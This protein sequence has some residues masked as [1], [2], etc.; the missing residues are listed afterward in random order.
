MDTTN[1]IIGFLKDFGPTVWRYVKYQIYHNNYVSE[2]Q[3]MQELLKDR[4]DVVDANLR[5]Q[6]MQ[7]GKI[8]NKEVRA[9]LDEAQRETAEE[10]IEDPI[11]KGGCF[12]YI[13]SSRKLDKKT[14]A[15][16]EGIFKRGEKYANGS[17]ILVVDDHSIPHCV[18]VF[19]DM[20]KE[21]KHQKEKIEATLKTQLMQSGKTAWQK[22]VD[23]LEKANQ[24]VTMKVED[25]VSQGESSSSTNIEGK[26]EELK[27]TLEEGKKLTNV[28]VSLVIDDHLK[29]GVPMPA[30]KC[31]A[32]D[33]VQEDI[34]QLLRGDKVTRIAVCGMGG[35]GKT[36]IMKQVYNQL[37]KE[38]TIK[39]VIWVK[40]SKDFDIV[41]QQKRRFDI[42]KFKKNIARKLELDLKED[43]DATELAG[44]LSQ[45]L[46]QGSCVLILDDVWEPFSVEDVGILGPDGNDACKLVLTTR[47]QVVARGMRCKEIYVK[48]LSDGEASALFLDKVESDLKSHPRFRSDIEP[49]FE[50]ILKKCNGLPLAIGV[51][52]TT[53][54][55]KF[56]HYSWEMAYIELSKSE[57]IVDSLKFSY[58]HLKEQYKKCFLHCALYPE[59]HEISK[60]ELIE[61]WIEEGFIIDER[62]SRHSMIC[63]GHVIFEKLIDNCMLELGKKTGGWRKMKELITSKHKENPVSMHDLLRE[64]TLKISPQ[65]MVKAGMA[66]EELPEEQEWREDLLKVSLMNN[67]IREIPSSMLSPKCPMLT[68]LLLS[69]NEITIIPEVF[70]DQMLGLKILD[71]SRNY[72][73]CSLSSSV[74]KLGNLTT[75]LLENCSSLKEVPSLS[76]L[77]GLK[78]LNLYGTS[79]EELPQGLNML[80]NLK[81]LWLGG[82]LSEIPDGLLLN[83][84]KLQ[85]LGV[86]WSI[87][88]KWGEI[89]RLRKLESLDGWF[90]TVDDMSLFLKSERKFPNRYRIFVGSCDEN[91]DYD[92]NKTFSSAVKLIVCSQIDICKEPNWLPS[93]AQGFYI[94]RCKDVRSLNDISGFQDV[95]DLRHCTVDECN[96][97]EFVVSSSCL[98]PLQN[99]ESLS[100]YGLPNL[101]A[102]FGEVGAVAKSAPLPAGTFS[103]L[104]RI[105]V[106]SCRKIKKLLP[107]R[108]LRY[109]QN[110]QTIKVQNCSEMEEIIWSED[111]EEGEKA[112]E[113]LTLPKL[114]RLLLVRLPS[115]K[116]IYSGSSTILICD[117]I[118]KVEIYYCHII[119]SVF[120]SGFNPL[121][122]L[123]YLKLE[124]LG[125]LK[126]MFDEEAIDLSALPTAFFS[127]KTI[128]VFD[129]P[130]LKK[131]FSSGWLLGYFQSLETIEVRF[132]EQMEEL[133]SSS[134]NEEKEALE[135]ITLPNLQWLKLWQLPELKSICSSS[136]VLIFDSIKNL[137]IG[138]CKKLKRIPL[139]L[140]SLDNGQPPSL[141]QICVYPKQH[142]ESL[143][144]DQSNAKDVLLPSVNYRWMG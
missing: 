118:K 41:L 9:W 97:L 34:L 102:V 27:R 106:Y 77:G 28:G 88:L 29:K 137:E 83:L 136:N 32:R 49:F 63:E 75:L 43:E 134:T 19:E 99:L 86:D 23:W 89:G 36:T 100:L 123:E 104:Q 44:R 22:V 13:C 90:S 56:D 8:E 4:R 131:V 21:V 142:W 47:L 54:R 120:W 111:E 61:F 3:K 105:K 122:T 60:E 87:P 94:F 17:E 2:F 107:L 103:S 124:Y 143:E 11:C 135:K 141:K 16:N 133:I 25:L 84:S 76:N 65:F 119:E 121:P 15:L 91:Y 128:N 20:Q 40:V 46:Q 5:T 38:P 70:F 79:I 26:L 85:Y 109:L 1:S 108:L 80:T 110:L 24:Q 45:N 115:L 62:G 126:S 68:T 140:S 81:Y 78:K 52:A 130:K 129:C 73:L 39:K 138:N 67:N 144:W 50:Q 10:V 69:N 55:G 59:D 30:E 6:V 113:K 37:L 48:P 58:D 57:E 93:D 7:R 95:T 92:Y 127:L 33:E 35:I 14:Q 12:T 117:S 72:K 64:M 82:R 51:V 116:S 96:G 125:N 74:S 101:N 53:M 18:S 71:L 98:K 31:I 66:L 114:K 139:H 42:L 112:P 132:C